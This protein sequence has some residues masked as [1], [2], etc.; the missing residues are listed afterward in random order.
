MSL[1][2]GIE[3]RKGRTGAVNVFVDGQFAFAASPNLMVEAGVHTG[4]ELTPREVEELKRRAVVYRA[5]NT[6]L[7]YL[8]ARPRSESEIRQRLRRGRFDRATVEEA[9][10]RLREKGLIDDV[11]FARFWRESRD[12]FRPRSRRLLGMELRQRGLRAEEIAQ[13]LG[14]VDDEANARA[15]ALTK[16]RSCAGL[17]YEA[18]RKRMAGFLRRRGFTFELVDKTIDQVWRETAGS[19]PDL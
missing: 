3:S 10:G 18:F 5:L 1:V 14:D 17:D 7:A 12:R 13:A 6:S 11:A 16:A 9:V 19:P 15:A 8:G 4:Q 2:T